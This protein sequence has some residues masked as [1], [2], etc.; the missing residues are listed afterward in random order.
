MSLS[1]YSDHIM[2]GGGGGSLKFLF[3][4]HLPIAAII[5]FVSYSVAFPIF[6]RLSRLSQV[7]SKSRRINKVVIRSIGVVV[8]SSVEVS[9][10]SA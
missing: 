10:H 7:S 3:D 9:N 2:G 6:S 1:L 4:L 5:E 8:M